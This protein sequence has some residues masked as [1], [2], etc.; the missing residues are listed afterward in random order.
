MLHERSL[1]C[2][3]FGVVSWIVCFFLLRVV[4]WQFCRGKRVCF[5]RNPQFHE[6]TCEISLLVICI[7]AAGVRQH[8][9]NRVADLLALPANHSFRLCERGTIGA[10]TEDREASRLVASHLSEQALSAG[11]DFLLTQL[12]CG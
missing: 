10:D 9:K 3:A 5:H 8:P 2:C 12:I 6:E 11:D 1:P 7:Q 4:F